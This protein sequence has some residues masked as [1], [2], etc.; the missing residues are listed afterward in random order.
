MYEYL[1]R[2]QIC[3][4]ASVLAQNFPL[5]LCEKFH[6]SRLLLG[7]KIKNFAIIIL[8]FT[9][10]PFHPP[11]PRAYSSRYHS[12]SITKNFEQYFL[13][14]E[15]FAF[16]SKCKFIMILIWNQREYGYI[17]SSHVYFIFGVHLFSVWTKWIK[18]EESQNTILIFQGLWGFVDF[19]KIFREQGPEGSVI[20]HVIPPA[21]ENSFLEFVILGLSHSLISHPEIKSS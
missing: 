3:S 20:N 13:T 18:K 19:S 15:M 1:L 7:V 21:S 11:L 8:Y 4:L 16:H 14:N 12:A 10:D 5:S 2:I 17:F 6:Q 9:S